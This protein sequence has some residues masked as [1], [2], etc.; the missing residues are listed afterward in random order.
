MTETS[1]W[2]FSCSAY[3]GKETE[4]L[5]L[6][7]QRGLQIN[8]ILLCGWLGQQEKTIEN[9]EKLIKICN[10]WET[11]LQPLREIRNQV[12]PHKTLYESCKKLELQF[13][14]ACQDELLSQLQT[15]QGGSVATNMTLYLSQFGCLDDDNI[16]A[17]TTH[18]QE[19]QHGS[20]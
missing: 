12:K 17:I 13:E 8:M 11:S 6:Q 2:H 5:Y 9:I 10:E 7:N 20:P 14:K 19:V 1:F 15:K 3:K 4:F 18:L 16:H